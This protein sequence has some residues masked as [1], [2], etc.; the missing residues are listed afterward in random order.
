MTGMMEIY[1]AERDK[2]ERELA[3]TK[4]V[5]AAADCLCMGLERVKIGYLQTISDRN[6]RREADRLFD[7]AK[8]AVRSVQAASGAEVRVLQD[9]QATPTREDKIIAL[10]PVAAIVIGAVLAVWMLIKDLNTPAVLCAVLTGLAWLEPQLLMK[11][12]LAL[13]A[14]VRVDRYELMCMLDRVAESIDDAL[15]A[16]P[17]EGG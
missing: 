14:R 16:E 3:E 11:R 1:Q 13:S 12:R 6:Q 2:I 5:K 8:Q 17:R 9:V 7:L 10:L 15:E 4:D